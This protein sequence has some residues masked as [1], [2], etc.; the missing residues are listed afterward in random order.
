MAAAADLAA[1]LL[2]PVA[3][4]D[5]AAADL[6][7][8]VAALLA[9][10]AA[11]LAAGAALLIFAPVAVAALLIVGPVAEADLAD[12]LTV[13]GLFAARSPPSVDATI[14]SARGCRW[15]APT[16]ARGI[17]ELGSIGDVVVSAAA[18]PAANFLLG[19][20]ALV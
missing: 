6:L 5:L 2:A 7:M 16:R 13:A 14:K 3:T 10:G 17:D 20:F 9:A 15:D 11:L 18:E 1:D 4:E 19:H 12:M 8:T